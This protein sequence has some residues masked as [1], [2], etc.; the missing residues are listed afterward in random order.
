MLLRNNLLALPLSFA[1]VVAPS[2]SS[3]EIKGQQPGIAVALPSLQT[4]KLL[5]YAKTENDKQ[6][7]VLDRADLQEFIDACQT[8]SRG[9]DILPRFHEPIPTRGETGISIFRKVSP[10]VVMVVTANFKDDKMTD[11][12]LGTGVI[13]DPAGYVLTNWHVVHGYDAGI[14]FLKPISGTEPD[15]NSAYGVKLVAQSEQA[16]L[17]LIKMIKPP[18]GLTAVKLG[19]ISS[20]QVAEDIHIIGHPHGQLWSYST[21]VVSQVRDH[22]DWQYSDG[23]K[24]LAKVLQMQTAINPGNSGGPVLDNNANMLGLVAMSEEGQN[25]NYAVAIDVIREFVNSAL[26]DRSRGGERRSATEKGLHY[27]A[28][29]N[30]GLSVIKTVYSNLVSYTVRDSKGVPLE[31][32]AESS[33]GESLTGSKANAFGGFSEWIY[34]PKSGKAISVKSSGIAPDLLSLAAEK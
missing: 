26:A 24:H 12:G 1:M 8:Y 16:D 31:L 33:E 30:D 20:V 15:K 9:L 6:T 29:T 22:Y 7:D 23:S 21:G 28:S 34:K 17:A 25:L 11:S 5:D 3:T 4:L 14:V 13:I 2:S 27:A 32:I 10:G 18:S 19:D